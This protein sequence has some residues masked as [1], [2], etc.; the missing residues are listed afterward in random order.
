MK[1]KEWKPTKNRDSQNL[2]TIN[3]GHLHFQEVTLFVTDLRIS[4]L[5]ALTLHV[6]LVYFCTQPYLHVA[7]QFPHKD[8]FSQIG[9]EGKILFAML[10]IS[11]NLLR[12]FSNRLWIG[13]ALFYIYAQR[14]WHSI[15]K[16]CKHVIESNVNKLFLSRLVLLLNFRAHESSLLWQVISTVHILKFLLYVFAVSYSRPTRNFSRQALR[17]QFIVKSL[18]VFFPCRYTMTRPIVF[19]FTIIITNSLCVVSY[20]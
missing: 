6:I 11:E 1:K 18:P 5:T 14:G 10:P 3:L 7:E 19:I 16:P 12:G 13:T 4:L 17:Y 2:S 8:G 15:M 20:S 9:H